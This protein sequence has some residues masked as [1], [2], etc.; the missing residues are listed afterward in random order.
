MRVRLDT[1]FGQRLRACQLPVEDKLR[2]KDGCKNVG[3]QPDNQRHGKAFHRTRAEQKEN[4]AGDDG[5]HVRIDNREDR[6]SKSR[7]DRRKNR[8]PR[9]QFFTNPLKDEDVAIHGHTN[10]QDDSRDAG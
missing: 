6:F 1:Y 9:P 2:D 4:G 7:V 5:R 3:N 10:G 8:L